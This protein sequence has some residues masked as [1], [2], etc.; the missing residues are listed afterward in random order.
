MLS[1]IDSRMGSYPL[2][3][4]EKFVGLALVC[5]Q[6]KPEK[7]PSMLDVVRELENI[8]KIIPKPEADLSNSAPSTCFSESAASSSSLAY[9]S[10]RDPLVSEAA[11]ASSRDPFVSSNVSGSDLTSGVISIITPR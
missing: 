1:L 7:R 5:C 8:L 2:D 4:I 9:A 3:C 11:Y 6:D 10:S